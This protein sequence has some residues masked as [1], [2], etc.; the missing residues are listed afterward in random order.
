MTTMYRARGFTLI[1]LLVV[2]SIIGLLASVVISSLN[3]ARAKAK[4]ARRLADM[5][6]IQQALELYN[7]SMNA[8]PVAASWRS[9]CAAW[10]SYASDQV[11]PGLVPQYIQAFPSD[12][13]MVTASNFCCYLYYS[14]G[15][16]YKL[17]NI[18]TNHQ[19][20]SPTSVIDPR[21]DGG[22]SNCTIDGATLT[23]WALFTSGGC[24]W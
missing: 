17:L 15:T 22:T 1:E 4:D 19:A 3:G 13:D 7:T 18:C 21:R 6:A 8:Y 9:Q 12:P 24:A 11:I 5:R 16:D 2:I 20:S 23:N 14:N 10:G